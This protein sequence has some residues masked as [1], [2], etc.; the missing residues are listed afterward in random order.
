MQSTTGFTSVVRYDFGAGGDDFSIQYTEAN[1]NLESAG[2]IAYNDNLG[3]FYVASAD[4]TQANHIAYL[5]ASAADGSIMTQVQTNKGNTM[6]TTNVRVVYES[7]N[8]H[9][10]IGD[11]GVFIWADPDTL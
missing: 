9:L 1:G 7:A 2:Y 4:S 10:Y 3:V 5:K 8:Q 11:H 6:S